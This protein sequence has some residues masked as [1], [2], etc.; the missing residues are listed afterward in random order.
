MSDIYLVFGD[1]SYDHPELRGAFLSF[2]DAVD[3]CKKLGPFDVDTLARYEAWRDAI[4]R[5]AEEN[6]ILWYVAEES[7]IAAGVVE[8]FPAFRYVAEYYYVLGFP[9]G[10]IDMADCGL[11]QVLFECDEHGAKI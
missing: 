9:L 11:A 8:R 3:F 6:N 2:D 10:A 7:A 1:H 5:Y 4:G